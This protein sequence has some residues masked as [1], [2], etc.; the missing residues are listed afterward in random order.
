RASAQAPTDRAASLP[1][2]KEVGAADV[3]AGLPAATPGRGFRTPGIL[4][5]PIPWAPLPNA[6]S[7]DHVSE[8][9]WSDASRSPLST[10]SIDVD[11]ASYANIRRLL[12]SGIQ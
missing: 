12:N 10:F 5:G 4:P 1:P 9:T 3:A 8:S 2:V 7:Y 6:D 11:T